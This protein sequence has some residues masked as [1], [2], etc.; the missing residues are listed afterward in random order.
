MTKGKRLIWGLLAAAVFLVL[1]ALPGC[2]V[3]RDLPKYW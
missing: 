2:G 3:M 1:L